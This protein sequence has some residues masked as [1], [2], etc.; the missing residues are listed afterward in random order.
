[1]FGWLEKKFET[2]GS[3]KRLFSGCIR[4]E[5]EKAM[6]I[7]PTGLT[8]EEFYNR[9]E[10]GTIKNCPC[11]LPYP[12]PIIHATSQ[13]IDQLKIA[14]ETAKAAYEEALIKELSGLSEDE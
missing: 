12:Q 13:T 5:Y 6:C 8:N 7:Y 2:C 14:Y 3:I 1:M 11:T 4:C 9:V 10:D